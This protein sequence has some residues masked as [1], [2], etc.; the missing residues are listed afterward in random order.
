MTDD[1]LRAVRERAAQIA[2]RASHVRLALD[3]IDAYAE[4]LEVSRTLCPELDPASHYVGHGEGTLAFILILDSINFGSGYFP[5]LRKLP[6]KSGYFTVATA[7]TDHFRKRGPWSAAELAALTPR[8]CAQVLGQTMSAPVGEL[9]RMYARAL[10]DLGAL[11]LRRHGGSFRELVKAADG[12]AVRLVQ[13]LIRMPLFNDVAQYDNVAVPFYKRAQLTAADLAL[14]FNGEGPGAFNDL[15]SLTIFADNLV[16]H[17]LRC[18]G[19]LVYE[20]PLSRTVDSGTLIPAGSAQE[21]EIRACAVHAVECLVTSLHQSG[22]DTTAMQ[23][24]YLLWNRGQGSA[25]KARPRHRT[26]TP[27]Y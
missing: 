19:L 5:H 6:G 25:Y 23:L 1:P 4:T 21:V 24:D 15:A 22:T 17:V 2:R 20:D 27:F 16:P 7:L 10:N 9:M 18:D 11:L 3:S 14:A 13:E 12:S 8:C 26:R